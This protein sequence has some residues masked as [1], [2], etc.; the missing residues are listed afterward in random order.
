MELEKK[1]L[2]VGGYVDTA[3]SWEALRSQPKTLSGGKLVD[4][5]EEDRQNKG[6]RCPE[7]TGAGKKP[8]LMEFS[9]IF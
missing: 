3:A 5:N 7:G 6:W 2:S 4:I 1:Y 8:T 9:S